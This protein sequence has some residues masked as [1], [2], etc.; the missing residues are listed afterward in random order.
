[1]K[2]LRR[3]TLALLAALVAAAP[4]AFADGA[5]APKH[6]LW[7]VSS[8]TNRVYLYGTVHAGKASWYPLPHA[9]EDAFEGSHI[10]AVE[11][12]V[13][14]AK[15]MQKSEASTIYTP[16]ANLTTQIPAADYARFRKLLPRYGIPEETIVRVKPFMASTMLVFSEWASAGYLPQYGVDLYLITRAKEENKQVVELEGVDEQ[17]K[18]MDSLSN[19][20]TLALFRGTVQ[21]LETGLARDQITGLVKAWQAGDPDGVLAVARSYNEKV[22]GAAQ[23]EERFI[24]SRHD[25]MVKKIAAYLDHGKDR[26]F[27]AVGALHL[28][29]PRGLVELLRKKGY[30]V[31]QL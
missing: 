5:T 21:S 11:A 1:M 17:I 27:V 16:P 7:E 15:A 29:G 26:Y 24:W 8:L 13:T 6:Y 22:E 14:D 12:D 23:F 25:A 18:L 20:E 31:K 28:A 30:V 4:C 3:I 9:I 2:P 19:D 10:L